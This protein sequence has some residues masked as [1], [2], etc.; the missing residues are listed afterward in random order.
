[1]KVKFL[2]DYHG[3][4]T[5]EV[6][7]IEGAKVELDDA[8]A[9]DFIARHI[10]IST[11]KVEKVVEVTDKPKVEKIIEVAPDKPKVITKRTKKH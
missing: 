6:R 3:P 4:E 1:M 5:S 8:I 9:T 2:R 10:V 11:E 7:H